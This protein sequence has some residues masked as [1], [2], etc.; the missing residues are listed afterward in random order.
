[1]DKTDLE[2]AAAYGDNCAE[3]YD[4]IYSRADPRMID[5]LVFLS[6]K[7]PVLELGIGTGRVALPLLAR[8]VT[9]SG[10]EASSKMI[11]KLK[12]KP[13]AGNLL[14]TQG[15]CADSLVQGPFT[16]V[17]SLVSTFCLLSFEEQQR[18]FHSVA[19]VLEPDG[20][21]LLENFAPS[22]PSSSSGPEWFKQLVKTAEGTREYASRVS[23]ASPSMLDE[24][25]ITAGLE[26]SERWADWSQR[27]Y[28]PSDS[29]HISL[30]Q[31]T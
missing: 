17:Y 23:Y 8:G 10:I 14:V 31:L 11:A 3:F 30:Y 6:K 28:T 7:G 13:G 4:Q 2:T 27:P 21:L 26:L 12:V 22:R 19:N 16:L 29:R 15:N 5:V 25:A 24:M 1:M 18:C 9:V 20:V